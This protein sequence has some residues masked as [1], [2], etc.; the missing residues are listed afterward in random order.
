MELV[1]STIN[2]SPCTSIN[3]DTLNIQY[4][5]EEADLKIIVHANE[6]VKR[7]YTNVYVISS[8]IDVIVLLLHFF[9][10]FTKNGLQVRNYYFIKIS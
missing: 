2:D 10:T 4:N 7:G 8:D 5:I 1:F 9:K 3:L 6:A